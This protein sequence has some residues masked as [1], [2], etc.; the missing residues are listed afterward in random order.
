MAWAASAPET[1]GGA[2]S[3]I[4]ISPGLIPHTFMARKSKQALVGEAAGNG[5]GAAAHIGKGLDRAV[6]AHHH[7][8][9]VAMA[10]VDDLDGHALRPKCN[11]QRRDDE[12]GLHLVGDERFLDLGKAL[13]QAGQ[14]DLTDR[15]DFEM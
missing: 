11:R 6:L 12:G 9:A 2:I 15:R 14:K 10:E 4:L 8:A 1:S 7:R 5:D 13:E 3:T